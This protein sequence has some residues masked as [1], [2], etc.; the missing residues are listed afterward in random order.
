MVL[1]PREHMALFFLS[2]GNVKYF[3][4]ALLKDIL[5]DYYNS[6]IDELERLGYI[7]N[8]N[9]IFITTAGLELIKN[10]NKKKED[11]PT[12]E[13]WI[14]EFRKQFIPQRMSDKEEVI[15]VMDE[16]INK[17]DFTKNE[18][19]RATEEYIKGTAKDNH[20]YQVKDINFITRKN[21]L[22]KYCEFI[23]LNEKEDN[24]NY[25]FMV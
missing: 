20:M 25:N 21:Q 9:S 6:S 23:R 1:G 2:K 19:I 15:K 8:N 3:E 17:Y 7:K 14:D 5:A 4:A 18:I 16:F 12:C 24:I 10:K 22:K 13:K 11:I